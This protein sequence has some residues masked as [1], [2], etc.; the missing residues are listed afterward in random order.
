MK[1]RVP[2]P[3]LSDV[4]LVYNF[5]KS[6]FQNFSFS[7]LLNNL[8]LKPKR[9]GFQSGYLTAAVVDL[10]LIAVILVFAVQPATRLI[11]PMVDS[12]RPLHPLTQN[13]ATK[14][15]FGFAPFW[16]FDQLDNVDFNI[17]TTFSY[18][19]VDVSSEGDLDRSSKGYETFRSKKA[20]DTFKKAHRAGTRVVLTLTQMK[21]D[22]ILALMD[23]PKAQD[24][25][26][27]QAVAEIKNRGIDGINVDFE[28]VGN[29]GEDYRNKFSSFVKNLTHRM[30]QEIPSS[31][32]TVS[33]YASAVKDPKIYDIKA[34]S[35]NSDG[36]FMMAYDFAVAGADEA[37]PTAPLNGYKEGKYWYDIETAVH[38]FL[39]Q[40][41]AEKLV[42]GLPWYGYNYLVYEPGVKAETRPWYSWRGKPATQPYSIALE[43][44][45]DHQDTVKEGWDSAGKVT[46]KAY[47]VSETDTW[48]MIFLDDPKSLAI[49]YD[50]AKAKN[51]GGVGMWALGFDEGKTEMWTTL[52]QHFGLKLADN[53]VSQKTIS[54]GLDENE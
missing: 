51:L 47:Y 22:P 35:K 10:I 7:Q 45:K 23:D 15:V 38:D 52:A 34:L 33:V 18:F 26:I 48:R 46:W 27:T 50:F 32:V 1:K 14:E 12:L 16:T 2:L 37:M 54:E 30:H 25:A 53:S 31:K 3:M 6:R 42:L 29:P 11:T 44:L 9:P 5:F 17:L 21:N 36:I 28:F 19:G 43:T 4:N 13:K 20:T 49:K 24:N 41:P 40:M 8:N 39:T